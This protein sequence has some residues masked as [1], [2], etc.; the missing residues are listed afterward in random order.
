M[1]TKKYPIFHL[2][3]EAEI[4]SATLQRW[5]LNEKDQASSCGLPAHDLR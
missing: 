1:T 2:F 5:I 4:F 3:D